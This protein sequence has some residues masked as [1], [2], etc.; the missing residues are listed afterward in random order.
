MFI[1]K[2][3][4]PCL[5]YMLSANALHSQTNQWTW[6]K[7]ANSIN[8]SGYNGT[9][10][11]P[12]SVNNPRARYLATSWTDAAGNLWMFGGSGYNTATV[13]EEYL[14]DLWKYNSNT[15]TWVWMKGNNT[16]GVSGVYGSQGIAAA[17]N[18]PGARR[19]GMSWKD[20]SGNFWLYGGHGFASPTFWGYLSDLWKFNPLTGQWTWVKG[21]T[22][23]NAA[24]IY[25]SYGVASPTNN[26]GGRYGSL[27]WTDT[28]G[29]FW[30]FGGYSNSPGGTVFFNDLW[31]FSTT[32]NQWTWIKGDSSANH[33]SVYG[34]KGSASP[35]ISLEA[36]HLQ[37]ATRML[38]ATSGFLE[39]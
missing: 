30:L 38:R 10:G 1:A 5:V 8:S 26:P 3:L 29:N 39:E 33:A 35:R 34:T 9:Q 22:T 7:G 24:P 13:L 37:Q 31:K 32:S 23:A 36:E 15:N 19:L 27:S 28:T 6:M 12:S 20:K 25:G 17:T 21:D 11:I 16:P 4:L 14:N 18:Q 2:R